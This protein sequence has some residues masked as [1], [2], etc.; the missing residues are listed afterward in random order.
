MVKVP[1]A[2]SNE[3]RVRTKAS[4]LFNFMADNS[5]SDC[6]TKLN[7]YL[8]KGLRIYLEQAQRLWFALTQASPFHFANP[9]LGSV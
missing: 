8:N 5:L 9:P 3:A 1:V 6:M 2:L 7:K 4:R